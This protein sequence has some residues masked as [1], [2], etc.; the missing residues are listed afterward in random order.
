[1]FYFVKCIYIYFS[2]QWHPSLLTL[3]GAVEQASGCGFNSLLCNLYRDGHDSIGW[4][5]DDEASLGHRPTI[6]SLSLGDTRVFGVR[7]QPPPVRW[8]PSGTGR[9]FCSFRKNK[10]CVI[11]RVE[12]NLICVCAL[13]SFRRRMTTTLMWSRFGFLS[14]TAPFW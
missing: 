14:V 13:H 3:R 8:G 11:R 1:M 7:K 2:S 6:A 4:H 10:S 5:S 12:V 9:C